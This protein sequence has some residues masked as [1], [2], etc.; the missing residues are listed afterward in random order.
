MSQRPSYMKPTLF[1]LDNSNSS[2][3]FT[4]EVHCNVMKNQ[5]VQR[6]P[7]VQQFIEEHT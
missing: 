3:L 4:Q 7:T 6:K 1:T 2:E 5:S